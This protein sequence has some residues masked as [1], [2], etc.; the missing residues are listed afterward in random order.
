VLVGTTKGIFTVRGGE[1]SGPA[2]A[3]E[4]VY[5]MLGLPGRDRLVVGSLSAHWGPL[6]RWSDDGGDTWTEPDPGRGPCFPVDT[7]ASLAAVWQLAAP[8]AQPDVLYAGVDPAALF[9]S[10]NGG[11]SFA[12]VRGLWEH[13]HRSQWTPGGGGLCLHSV[14]V[15]PRDADSLYVAVSSAG[16]YRSDDGGRTWEARNRGIR[17]DFLPDP[18]PEFGQ[19]VHKIAFDAGDT[20]VLYLQNHGGVYRSDDGAATWVDIGGDLP[21]DFGFALVA[22]PRRAGTAYIVPLTSDAYRCTPEGRMR[23]YRTRDHGASWQPLTEGL[24]QHAAHLTVLRDAFCHDGRD[25]LGLYVGTRTGQVYASN[26]EGDSWTLLADH[27]PPVLCVRT[28][29]A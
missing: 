1:V 17:A 23:V 15:D 13:H 24:P 18:H 21:S 25:P 9:R 8:E 12:L 16:V 27:L 20:D 4:P 11:E 6:L 5:S 3:G 26:D 2:L 10:D 19:C 29:S 28:M 22:H 14:L 7:G